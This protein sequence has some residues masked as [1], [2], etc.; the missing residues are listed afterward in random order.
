MREPVKGRTEAGR[1]RERRA[2]ATRARVVQSAVRLFIEHGYSATTVVD[3]ARDAGSRQP[4]STKPVRHQAGRARPR[5]GH[6]H[7]RRPW[8][9]RTP[10]PRLGQ[11]RPGST[12]RAG[13]T[14]CRP[15]LHGVDRGRTAALKEVMRDAAATD[16]RIR[17]LIDSDERQRRV[18]QRSL[19][20]EVI[21]ADALRPGMTV[22]RA[23]DTFYLLVNS[24]SYTLA[25]ASLGWTE[26]TW[27]AWLLES[28]SLAF[29]GETATS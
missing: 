19:V 9:G 7:R 11:E 5:L 15:R 17:E 2:R 18:T 20:E 16:L 25:R 26:S 21:G 29:F 10:R 28:L 4:P 27:K 14:G 23:S 3:I 1:Q 8:A 13:A 6:H 22:D 24:R 12:D